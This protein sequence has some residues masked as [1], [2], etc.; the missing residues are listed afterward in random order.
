VLV[1]DSGEADE[2][3]FVFRNHQWDAVNEKR[4][5]IATLPYTLY[6]ILVRR[7]EIVQMLSVRF[8]R[9]ELHCLGVLT[10]IQHNFCAVPQQIE[11]LAISREFVRVRHHLAQRRER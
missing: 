3:A 1:V 10:G 6:A 9:D 8:K 7:C 2:I 4:C 5:I 11:R